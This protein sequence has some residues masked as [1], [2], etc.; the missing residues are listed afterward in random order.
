M[1]IWLNSGICLSLLVTRPDWP[2][3]MKG[4]KVNTYDDLKSVVN[5]YASK[6][7][8]KGGS[9][10]VCEQFLKFRWKGIEKYQAQMK[11]RFGKVPDFTFK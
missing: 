8:A 3:W 7:K 11:D 6:V 5:E 1:G 9:I 10:H 2:E 4:R